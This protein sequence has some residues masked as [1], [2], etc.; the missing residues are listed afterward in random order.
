MADYTDYK[1][2]SRRS[3]HPSGNEGA[4]CTDKQITVGCLQRIAD[5]AELAAR[6]HQ[7]LIDDRDHCKRSQKEFLLLVEKAR[8]CNAAL[9]G[10]VTKLKRQVAALKADEEE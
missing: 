6:R 8:R 7:E 10:V 4:N 3:W 5:A 1:D 2:Q 9:R